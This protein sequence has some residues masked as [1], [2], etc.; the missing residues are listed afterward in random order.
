MKSYFSII[1]FV[2]F[3]L[4]AGLSSVHS[5][6]CTESAIVSDMNQALAQTLS[7]KT[8]GWITPDTIQD[9]REHLRITALRNHS[10]LYYAMDNHQGILCSKKMQW[11]SKA[12][13]VAFQSYANCSMATI[14]GLSDQR[15]PIGCSI[16][17]LLWGL[18]SLLYFKKNH[19][20]MGDF[21]GLVYSE[22]EQCFYNSHHENIV[23]TPMQMQLMQ[24]FYAK[25]NHQLTKQEICE[26]LWPK[27]PDASATLYTLIKRLKPVIGAQANLKIE[28]DRGRNYRLITK[29]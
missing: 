3:V 21:G 14:W 2:A 18:F 19:D 11:R 15:M 17:A 29:R 28:T 27:K 1:V 7:R 6:Q 8:E 16:L 10:F 13:S 4:I 20:E 9:Y 23:F 25:A 22:S 5:Y 12:K 24:L 26:A